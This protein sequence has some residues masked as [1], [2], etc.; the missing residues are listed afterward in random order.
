MYS[1]NPNITAM[2]VACNAF[3]FSKAHI[4]KL[5]DEYAEIAAQKSAAIQ[6]G[7]LDDSL[8][9][10]L[11][12]ARYGAREFGAINSRYK[13]REIEEKSAVAAV[14]VARKGGDGALAGIK[15]S[16][17]HLA[18]IAGGLMAD[19]ISGLGILPVFAQYYNMHIRLVDYVR[20]TYLD[21]VPV[22]DC[23]RFAEIAFGPR[24]GRNKNNKYTLVWNCSALQLGPEPGLGLVPVPDPTLLKLD[25]IQRPLRAISTYAI[26]ELKTAAGVLGVEIAPTATKRVIYDVLTKHCIPPECRAPK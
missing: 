10:A 22:G 14:C 13:N 21:V 16:R 2:L 25:S 20:K 7:E 6:V 15:L 11:F 26:T 19:T 12:I 3:V 17:P 8:F 9:W 1:P 18:T 24:P 4:S 23:S 5:E